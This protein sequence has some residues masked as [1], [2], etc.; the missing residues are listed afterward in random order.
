MRGTKAM[1]SFFGGEL[2]RKLR[3][4]GRYIYGGREGLMGRGERERERGR[5][6]AGGSGVGRK[7]VELAK[8]GEGERRAEQGNSSQRRFLRDHPSNLTDFHLDY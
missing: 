4:N 1:V 6:D 2:S 7:R 3:E 5:E 8:G